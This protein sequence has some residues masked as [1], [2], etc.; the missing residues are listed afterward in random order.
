LGISRTRAPRPEILECAGLTALFLFPPKRADPPIQSGVK[1]PH[2][3]RR[4]VPGGSPSWRVRGGCGWALRSK[5]STGRRESGDRGQGTSGGAANR[6]KQ[7]VEQSGGGRGR[8]PSRAADR[9]GA[10]LPASRALSTP[11]WLGSNWGGSSGG[12]NWRRAR[13]PRPKIFGV[14]R[15][16]GAFSFPTKASRSPN[17][18]RRQAA[19]LQKAPRAGG[20]TLMAG[21]RRV[22]LG[23]NWGGSSGRTGVSPSRRLYELE[24]RPFIAKFSGTM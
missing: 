19:A 13:A 1:P 24:A 2:S 8:P 6:G 7:A 11:G 20:I 12:G 21:A 5:G 17:P 22:W 9:W 18:K 14:R 10:S 15:L 23:S 4:H 16:D 3:K